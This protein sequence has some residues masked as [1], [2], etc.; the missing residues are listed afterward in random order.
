MK[1]CGNCGTELEDEAA[2]CTQCGSRQ[3]YGTTNKNK[4]SQAAS[5][6]APSFGYAALGFFMPMIGLILYLVWNNEYPLR[7]KSCGK[8]A[9]IG[10]I[11]N[12]VLG[13]CLA[14]ARILA[15]EGYF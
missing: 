2:F 9:I 3:T 5:D 1:Y 8:G 12:V 15:E 10:F 6:D 7:A 14:V 11:I 13:V 4:Y